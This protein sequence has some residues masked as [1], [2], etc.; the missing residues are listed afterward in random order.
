MLLSLHLLAASTLIAWIAALSSR[1]EWVALWWALPGG[2]AWLLAFGW[3]PLASGQLRWDGERW[4]L[5]ESSPRAGPQ[6]EGSLLLALDA[7]SWMLLQF[8]SRREHRR[9]SRSVW[10]VL[11]RRASADEW[12]ALRRTV[13]SPRPEPA[14]ASAQAAANSP[15]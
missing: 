12:S 13:Y 14:T 3:M 1:G 8:R 15:A 5:T 9:W 2:L 6:R 7:G 4:L 11:A 10:M